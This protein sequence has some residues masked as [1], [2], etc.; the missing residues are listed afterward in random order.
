VL[1][2]TQVIDRHPQIDAALAEGLADV[3]A[4][5]LSPKFGSMEAYQP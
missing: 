3:R 2:P 1:T 4:G 5:R